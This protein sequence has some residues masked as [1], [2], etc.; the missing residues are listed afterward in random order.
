MSAFEATPLAI[1][2]RDLGR[3]SFVICGVATE[4]GIEPTVRHGADL[5]LIP[6]VVRDACGA[7]HAEAGDRTFDQLKFMGDAVITDVATL[8]GTW[9]SGSN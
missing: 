7:G 9:A 4:I 5:G 6:V 8:A 1:A 2:L 3:Q